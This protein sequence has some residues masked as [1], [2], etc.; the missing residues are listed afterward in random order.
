M[1]LYFRLMALLLSYLLPVGK[2]PILSGIETAFRVYPTDLDTNLHM[3]NGRYLTLM[4]LG[5]LDLMRQTGLLW[6]T[7][8]RRWAAIL[9]ATQMVYLYPLKLGDAFVIN[10][11]LEWWDDKWFVIVQRFEAKGRVCAIGRVRGLFRGPSG[12]VSVPEV[13]ALLPDF[14]RVSPK[15]SLGT[16]QWLEGLRVMRETTRGPSTPP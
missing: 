16:Q 6:P 7:T 1:N 9:G 3:N 4:D 5:R 10:T 13:M 2:R 8:K 11:Q 12:N 15:A 14:P